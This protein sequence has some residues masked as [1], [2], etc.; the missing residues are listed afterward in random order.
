MK[1]ITW[2]HLQSAI[3]AALLGAVGLLGTGCVLPIPTNRLP[4]CSRKDIRPETINDLVAGETTRE[5]VLLRLGE[6]DVW[7][8]DASQ[9]RY[10]WERVKWDILWAIGGY[11]GG[12]AGDIPVNKNYN[13]T[14]T[15]DTDGVM[16]ERKFSE[17][18]QASELGI[19]PI[20]YH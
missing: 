14:V 2:S 6:P 4:D 16:L 10:H 5:E 12:A 11:G 8:D 7:S 13:L 3:L 17:K 18:Y 1:W 15:F 9:Y 20:T 19:G